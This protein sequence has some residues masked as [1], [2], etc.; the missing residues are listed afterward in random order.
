MIENPS[1]AF[2]R[3]WRNSSLSRSFSQYFF[4]ITSPVDHIIIST[5]ISNAQRA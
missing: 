1:V 5:R 2:S 4:P 3:Y